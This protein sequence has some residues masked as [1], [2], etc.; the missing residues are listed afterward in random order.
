MAFV[1]GG[2]GCRASAPPPLRPF[3]A[4]RDSAGIHV[5]EDRAASW[6]SGQAWSTDSVTVDLGGPDGV[7]R[8]FA[9]PSAMT[10]LSDGRIVVADAGLDELVYFAGDGH[11]LYTVGS[12]GRAPGQFQSLWGVF[13]GMADSVV[14]YDIALS[15]ATTFD[16]NGAL[17]DT[18]TFPVSPGTNGYLP[19]GRSADGELTLLRNRTPVPFPGRAWSVA[20]DSGAAL[21]FSP[22]GVAVD[23]VGPFP[24]SE[25]VG[26]P[27]PQAGGGT[28]M[29]P[30]D[31]PLGRQ[32]AFVVQGD[33]MWM[34]TGATPSI[35]R[36][37]AGRHVSAIQWPG[38]L[39]VVPES[40]V[41]EYKRRR[42]MS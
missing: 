6:A 21:R 28:V 8:G 23:S 14:A 35:D 31:R 41:A 4:V 36:Y 11:F 39:T 33:T 10:R 42:R 5:I 27:V 20:V 37:V 24:V 18:V 15:R 1:I 34:T 32:A 3:V 7:F 29:V 16:P 30:I 13:R 19:L 12:R 9:D 25:L 26:L 40:L 22:A 2:A 38:A 17:V